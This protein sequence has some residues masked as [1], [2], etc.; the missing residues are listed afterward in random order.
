[1]TR[2]LVVLP[3]FASCG[4]GLETRTLHFGNGRTWSEIQLKDGVPQGH[5]RTWYE[6]GQ[7]RTEGDYVGGKRS[8]EWT[9]WWENGKQQSEGRYVDGRQEGEW[10]YWFESGL[11]ASR[12]RLVHGV[13]QGEWIDW[14][15]TG[16][17]RSQA[18]F[19]DGQPDLVVRTFH[20][21]G[22]LE[23]EAT[24]DKGVLHGPYREYREDG[25]EWA[26]GEYANGKQANLW[27]VYRLDGSLNENLSGFFEDGERV[28]PFP[29]E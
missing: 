19:R 5:W 3:L 4:T 27:A 23:R 22:V 7:M 11:P 17:Q 26:L 1:V 13:A 16:T 15:G 29:K 6:S 28:R 8:G 9:T 24:Y 18:V 12:G 2:W 20:P 21:N 14:Y 25:R 10:S